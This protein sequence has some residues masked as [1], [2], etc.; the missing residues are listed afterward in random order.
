MATIR[1]HPRAQSRWQVRY[2]DAD[3]RQRARNFE[4]KIDADRFAATVTADVLRGEYIDPRLGHTTF[5]EFAERWTATRGHLAQSTQD[6]DRHY[7]SSL[8]LPR[9]S[10]RAVGSLRQSEIAAWV[11]ALDAAPAT[12][13]KALQKLSAVL[14]LA[15]ADGALKSNPA[16]GVKRPSLKTREGRAMTDN[17]VWRILEAAEEVDPDKAAMVWIM[18]RAGL[19]V[20]E[21]LALKRADVDLAA[22]MLHVGASMSRREG[23]RPVKGRGGRG[24]RIPMSEDLAERLGIHMDR[25]LASIDGWLFTAPKGG[26]V[27]YNNW[28]ARTWTRIVESAGVGDVKAHDLRHTVATRLFVVDGWSVP[29]VQAFLGHVDPTITLRVYTHVNSESLPEPSSGH[30]VDTRSG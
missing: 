8:I 4:R 9:F 1:R 11:S 23:V 3:G 10:H 28:R 15:V 26:R 30:I 6:Q 13:V 16:D 25:T 19:R 5:G 7:M 22:R 12:K 14:R 2:R 21:V 27:R 18:A 24:R 17:E 29:Q 20:G